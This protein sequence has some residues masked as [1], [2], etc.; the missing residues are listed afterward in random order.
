MASVN[1]KVNL[2]VQALA[3]GSNVVQLQFR[4]ISWENFPVALNNYRIVS[5]FNTYKNPAHIALLCQNSGHSVGHTTGSLTVDNGSINIDFFNTSPKI[6]PPTQRYDKEIIFPF[7]GSAAIVSAGSSF[8]QRINQLQINSTTDFIAENGNSGYVTGQAAF[9][10]SYS[11]TTSNSYE[12]NNTFILEF[13]DPT[14]GWIKVQEYSN[15]TTPDSNT[16]KY[17]YDVVYEAKKALGDINRLYGY[18]TGFDHQRLVVSIDTYIDQHLPTSSFNSATTFSLNGSANSDPSSR[19]GLFKFDSN[20]LSQLIISGCEFYNYWGASIHT[21][22]IGCYLNTADVTSASTWSTNA[23]GIYGAQEMTMNT[24][25]NQN[26]RDSYIGFKIDTAEVQNWVTTSSTNLGLNLRYTAFA[27]DERYNDPTVYLK[28]NGTYYD[29]VLFVYGGPTSATTVYKRW[30]GH[31]NSNWSVGSNWEGGV[32]PGTTDYATFDSSY[33]T[34][35]CTL[36]SNQSILNLSAVG[37][38]YSG[39]IDL[40]SS[41][42]SINDT[43]FSLGLYSNLITSAST[44]DFKND[45][46]SAYLSNGFSF[47]SVIFENGATLVNYGS[48]SANNIQLYAGKTLNGFNQTTIT[49]LSGGTVQMGSSSVMNGSLRLTML[50]N[51]Q[52]LI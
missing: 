16:G 46:I 42:L 48:F 1:D 39:Q 14:H 3:L 47:N 38:V 10:T 20:A 50:S 7:T 21:I 18:D 40:G 27:V 31:T 29:P 17:P 12:D 24:G 2:Q 45:A 6:Y 44:L 23:S 4:F 32:V 36:D 34:C 49:I 51:A 5:Y 33:S 37:G 9:S 41:T 28:G 43:S 11:Y 35:A 52:I 15:A 13:N 8:E 30:Q 26:F 25:S 19:I 22:D